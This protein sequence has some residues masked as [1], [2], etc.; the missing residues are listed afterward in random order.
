M[1]LGILSSGNAFYKIDKTLFN[2]LIAVIVVLILTIIMLA[3]SIKK[4]ADAQYRASLTEDKLKESYNKLEAAYKDVSLTQKELGI[5]YEELKRS[6]ENNRKIAY[7]DYLTELPNRTAF[8]E[9]LEHVMNTLRKEE[10][11]AVMYIDLDN[12]KNINDILGHSYGDELL[13]DVTHRLKQAIDENDYLARFGGDE[14]IVLSQNIEDVGLFEEKIRKIQK[15]FSFPFVLSLKEF[16]V[17]I[18][19]G[20]AY[21]PKDGKTTQSLIKNVDLAMYSAK[22]NGK[23]TYCFYEESI[24]NRLLNKIEIQS[25]LRQAI[26]H[27]EFEVYYQAQIDLKTNKISGFE[28]LIR[29]N[30]P[31]KGKIEPGEFIPIAEQTGL[32]VPIGKWVMQEACKQLKYWEDKGF[33]VTMA[34][35]I[36]SRQFFDTDLVTMVKETIDATGI[37]PTNLELEITESVVL[38]NIE[39]SIEVIEQIREFGVRFSL[40]DFGTGYSAMNYLRMLPVSNLKIDKSF[41]DCLIENQ[42]DQKIVSSIINLA[43][44]LDLNVIAEGVEREEQAEFLRSIDCKVA[45]GF[46]YSKPV[47]KADAN[48]LLGRYNSEA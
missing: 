43:R 39:Y 42:S 27:N 5:K 7:T 41:L 30:H 3:I 23:N 24:N 38:D 45:Q 17:T 2:I 40:D 8:T 48:D 26:D 15:V 1:R 32:I 13:I 20:V 18:S 37:N 46:L 6:E 11:V 25:E 10:V 22:E 21:A 19:I 35:N 16:F 36:S 4:R 12:F 44:N 9:R 34:V 31:V 14:F 29:W 47:P 33:T 28:A